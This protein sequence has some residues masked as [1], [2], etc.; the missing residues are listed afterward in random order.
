VAGVAAALAVALL[1]WRAAG[2]TARGWR[3]HA[4]LR[5]ASRARLWGGG[6]MALDPSRRAKQNVERLSADL[7]LD[8]EQKQRLAAIIKDLEPRMQAVRESSSL[9]LEE[10]RIRIGA[11]RQEQV[12]RLRGVLTLEQVAQLMDVRSHGPGPYSGGPPGPMRG[13]L[14]IVVAGPMGSAPMSGAPMGPMGGHS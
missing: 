10:R 8:G 14:G 4:I 6:F 3:E 2:A 9:S 5:T 1:T 11:L 13:G 12:D 7:N